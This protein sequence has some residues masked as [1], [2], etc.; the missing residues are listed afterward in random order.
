MASLNGT[1]NGRVPEVNFGKLTSGI[2]IPNL[3]DVQ[4]RAFQTLLQTNA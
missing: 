4:V 2:D 1:K 3:L